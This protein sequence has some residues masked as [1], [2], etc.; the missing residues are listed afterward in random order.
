MKGK[1]IN[2]NRRCGGSTRYVSCF[3]KSFFSVSVMSMSIDP[4]CHGFGT[5]KGTLRLAGLRRIY[6]PHPLASRRNGIIQHSGRCGCHPLGLR[7]PPLPSLETTFSSA[8][9]RTSGL[10]K[11]RSIAHCQRPHIK[12]KACVGREKL[13]DGLGFVR[14]TSQGE[15]CL[16]VRR[17]A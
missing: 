2:R 6:T 4:G 3:S 1:R 15:A 11:A 14:P 13:D 16:C 5:S 12:G 9:S 17:L 8:M 10:D 7:L